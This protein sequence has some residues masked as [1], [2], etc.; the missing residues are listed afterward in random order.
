MAHTVDA[1]E[2]PNNHPGCSKNPV[3]NGKNYR[4]LNWWVYRISEPSTVSPSHHVRTWGTDG[5]LAT[6]CQ[7]WLF[8]VS[9]T[10]H[11]LWGLLYCLLT[12]S[13]PHYEGDY[14]AWV[15]LPKSGR[16]KIIIY[17]N[18]VWNI[19]FVWKI[20]W[21]EGNPGKSN[22]FGLFIPQIGEDEPILTSIFFRWVDQPP[23][24]YT[25]YMSKWGERWPVAKTYL[26]NLLCVEDESSCR[27][28]AGFTRT[29]GLEVGDLPSL[30]G[31]EFLFDTTGG[32][33]QGINIPHL[34]KR[35]IIFK[36]A[37]VGDMLVP[38]RVYFW[39]KS[40]FQPLWCEFGWHCNVE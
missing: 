13:L 17:I 4:S 28:N 18:L 16:L 10:N 5:Y 15:L 9:G 25:I 36:S 6:T 21:L 27:P 34:G 2:I 11:D 29:H 19:L 22:I 39:T 23:T 12:G 38:W 35:K 1:S 14:K 37:L 7:K 20:S 3:D 32:T 33:L 31:F 26:T 30:R 40:D 8:P 24:R